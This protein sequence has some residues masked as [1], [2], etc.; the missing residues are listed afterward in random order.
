MADTNAHVNPPGAEWQPVYIKKGRGAGFWIAVG[1]ASFFFLCTLF[2]FILFIGSLLLGRAFL[3][4]T[5]EGKKQIFETIVEGKGEDKIAIVPIK[6]I[7]TNESG[8]GLFIEKH[9]IV[10]AVKQDLEQATQDSHVKAVILEVNSPGGGITASDVIYNRIM[11]FK[12]DTQKKVVV[13]MG[14]I[15]ASGGYYI[16]AA[17]DAIVAHPTT[18]TGSIGV[19]MPL[20]N[21]AEL[22]NRYGIKDNSIASGAMKEIGSPFKQMTPEEANIL[23]DII[24]ELYMQFVTVVS[25]GRSMDVETVKKLADGRIYTGKQAVEKGLVDRLGYLEDAIHV[26]R[27]LSGLSE[28]TVVRYEKPSGLAGMFGLL[29]RRLFQNTTINLDILQFYEQDSIK[30]MYLW[31]GHTINK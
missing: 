25:T 19:I 30:P 10:E 26:T 3:G 22:I 13:Y 31:T 20:I 23:K 2:L 5:P 21:V 6:G 11:K 1:I 4:V 24:H 17:A 8:D 7:L 14:D 29:S 12:A 18:I 9:S 28:A 16:S 15:A 27:K